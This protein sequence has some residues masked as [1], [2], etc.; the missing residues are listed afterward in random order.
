MELLLRDAAVEHGLIDIGSDGGEDQALELR[1]IERL[2]LPLHRSAD[3]E[4]VP[5]GEPRPPR[6]SGLPRGCGQLVLADLV[7]REQTRFTWAAPAQGPR[8]AAVRSLLIRY[9]SL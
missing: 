8:G 3:V 6:V 1:G 9:G 5:A 4:P 2:N 7:V